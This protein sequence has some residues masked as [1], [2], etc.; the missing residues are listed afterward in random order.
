MNFYGPSQ[1]AAGELVPIEYYN[2]DGTLVETREQ[3]STAARC[4]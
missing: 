1:N 4:P 2:I 3:A